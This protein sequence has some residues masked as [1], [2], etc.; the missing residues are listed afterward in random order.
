MK[1]QQEHDQ[2]IMEKNTNFKNHDDFENLNSQFIECSKQNQHLNST[3]QK[4]MVSND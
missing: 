2:L 1:L 3:L 4:L